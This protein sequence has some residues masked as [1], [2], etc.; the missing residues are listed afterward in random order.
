MLPRTFTKDKMKNNMKFYLNCRNRKKKLAIYQ[1]G[2]INAEKLEIMKNFVITETHIFK[3][4]LCTQIIEI[5]GN[6]TSQE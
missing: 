6:K 5:N 2:G 1:L 4:K 3:E